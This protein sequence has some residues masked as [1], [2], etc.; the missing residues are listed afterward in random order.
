V[1]IRELGLKPGMVV[2]DA[3]RRLPWQHLVVFSKVATPQV[4]SRSAR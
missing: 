1:L 4:D 2:A 3:S